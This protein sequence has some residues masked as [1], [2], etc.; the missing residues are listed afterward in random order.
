MTLCCEKGIEIEKKRS[1]IGACPQE[2]KGTP[3]GHSKIL[4]RVV[5]YE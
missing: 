2:A 3:Q 1:H 5:P 4:G